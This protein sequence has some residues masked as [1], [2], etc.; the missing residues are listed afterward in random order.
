[1]L[2][3]HPKVVAIGECGLDN[4]RPTDVEAAK[5][6]QRDV[7]EQHVQLAVELR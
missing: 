2:A 1:M 5:G 6:K 4:F 7:F 3:A